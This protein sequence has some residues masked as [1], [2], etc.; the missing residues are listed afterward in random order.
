MFATGLITDF[1]E[2]LRSVGGLI[3]VI[4]LLLALWRLFF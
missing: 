4:L 2:E 1:K 3:G